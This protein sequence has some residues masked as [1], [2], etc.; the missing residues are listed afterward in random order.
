MAAIT[1]NHH[2]FNRSPSIENTEAPE[3]APIRDV[4]MKYLVFSLYVL[5]LADFG[6]R[7]LKDTGR[8]LHIYEQLSTYIASALGLITSLFKWLLKKSTR[9]SQQLTGGTRQHNKSHDYQGRGLNTIF[10]TFKETYETDVPLFGDLHRNPNRSILYFYTLLFPQAKIPPGSP[11]NGSTPVP[12][13]HQNLHALYGLAFR[14]RSTGGA[15]I[16]Q[17]NPFRAL[18]VDCDAKVNIDP[19]SLL[20]TSNGYL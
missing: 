4:R 6:T 3:W 12:V 10:A 7:A 14:P 8:I 16:D 18:T 5:T 20:R 17:V 2:E 15:S 11:S 13:P 1:M 9:S 19:Y